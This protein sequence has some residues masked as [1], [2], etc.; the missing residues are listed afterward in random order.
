MISEDLQ[1]V[2]DRKI[3][4]V[5]RRAYHAYRHG[6]CAWRAPS[7][8]P[9]QAVAAA[10]AAAVSYD[11]GTASTR[12]KIFP[13]PG[14]GSARRGA[15]ACLANLKAIPAPPECLHMPGSSA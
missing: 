8:D 6:R 2:A 9:V 5:G 1:S 3:Y 15:R 7:A 4:G 12:W 13:L 14:S 11:G 10:T